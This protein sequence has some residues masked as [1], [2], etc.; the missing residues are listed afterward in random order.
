MIV[1]VTFR[2]H[3]ISRGGGCGEPRIFLISLDTKHE[4]KTG[5]TT[6]NSLFEDA[7]S[8]NMIIL[9]QTCCGPPPGPSIVS[10]ASRACTCRHDANQFQ[11]LP[12]RILREKPSGLTDFPP[13]PSFPPSRSDDNKRSLRSGHIPSRSTRSSRRF[14]LMPDAEH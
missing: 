7:E 14:K 1:T 9:R 4:W 3:F 12:P 5:Y 2:S 6:V 13:W 10:D 11:D 8:F